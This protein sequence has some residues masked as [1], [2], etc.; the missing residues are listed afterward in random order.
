MDNMGKH[1]ISLLLFFGFAS[2]TIA[3]D[4]AATA[5]WDRND[6]MAAIQSANIGV[7]ISEIGDIS[8]LAD[9]ATTLRKLRALETRGDW[10]LPAREAAIYQFTRSLAEV[11][12]DAVA[13][14]VM[15]HL[16][17]YQA[18]ALVPHE[19]RLDVY[20]PLFNIRG[21]ATGVENTWQRAESAAEAIQLLEANPAALTRAYAQSSSHPQRS[22]YLDALQQADMNTV[23]SVQDVA[24]EQLEENPGLTALLARTAVITTDIFAVQQLLINGQ[25]AGLSSALAQLDTRLQVSESAEL[26]AFAIQHAPAT[27]AT[28]AIAAWW[29]RLKHDPA[30]RDLLIGSLADPALG[31]AAALALAQSPDIQTIRALQ[32]A[33]KGGSNAAKRAQMALDLDRAGL[34]PGGRP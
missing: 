18:R 5:R 16:Q 2:S 29:P 30:T 33:A 14:E 24:L 6:A 4:Q 7:A 34:A 26:L 32:L 8:S 1:F 19:E 11:P 17:N 9:G 23:W 28:L 20:V 25:G 27:N 21:L 22:G 10:P 31:A 15:Q 12:R 3:N 13:V